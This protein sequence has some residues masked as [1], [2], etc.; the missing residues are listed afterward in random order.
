MLKKSIHFTLAL[1]ALAQLQACSILYDIQQ[2]MAQDKCGQMMDP[3]Q[4][5]ECTK[6]NNTSFEQ[7]E[8]Q[9]QELK[10]K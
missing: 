4:R 8:K 9:R 5:N 1:I 6:R 7:Y 2:D 10:Q 3:Y